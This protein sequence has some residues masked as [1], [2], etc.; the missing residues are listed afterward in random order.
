ML[1]AILSVAVLLALP[2]V[3]LLAC[4][5]RPD[6]NHEFILDLMEENMTENRSELTHID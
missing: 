6:P 1:H 5:R 3:I 2:V 4:C